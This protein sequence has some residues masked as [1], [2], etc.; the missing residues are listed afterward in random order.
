MDGERCRATLRKKKRRESEQSS[1]YMVFNIGKMEILK[2]C[3]C[4]MEKRMCM[5]YEAFLKFQ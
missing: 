3:G 5:T 2:F 1:P 4:K